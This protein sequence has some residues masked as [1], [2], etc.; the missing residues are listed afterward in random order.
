[1]L[2]EFIEIEK[3]PAI[4]WG[5]K[6]GS[7]YIYVHGKNANKEEANSFAEKA[8]NKGFQVLSFDLPEHGERINENYPCVVWNG[9]RDLSIVGAY[10]QQNWNEIYLYGSSIGAYFSLLAYK[11]IPLKKCLF[12]SPILDMERLIQ[13]MMR[14]FN[15][16]EKTLKEKHEI[17]TPIGEI[18][19]WDYYCYARNNPIDRWD[20][21]TAILCGSGDNLTEQEVVE[22]F[23]KRFNCDLTVLDGGEHWFHT[24]RQLTFLE[25][26]LK[27]YV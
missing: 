17:Q 5:E 16:S 8:V 6:A 26:W 4:L 10:V 9:V 3:I 21:P 27:K 15:V 7:I 22:F 1:M 11:D 13:N 18:L 2:K 19:N 23:A 20:V 14:W 12:L 24:E 25:K